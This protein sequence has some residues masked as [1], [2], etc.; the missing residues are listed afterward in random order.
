MLEWVYNSNNTGTSNPP[1]PNVPK[2][3]VVSSSQTG[4]VHLF[5][6]SGASNGYLNKDNTVA[7]FAERDRRATSQSLFV[8]LLK[9]QSNVNTDP[10]PSEWYSISIPYESNAIGHFAQKLLSDTGVPMSGAVSPPT[11]IVTTQLKIIACGF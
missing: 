3:I 7:F 2:W 10:N 9:S 6:K 11:R 4:Q 1:P 5:Y 8:G